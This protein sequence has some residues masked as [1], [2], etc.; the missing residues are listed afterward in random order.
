MVGQPPH[1]RAVL[2]GRHE[3]TVTPVFLAAADSWGFRE[4]FREGMEL[5]KLQWLA[6]EGAELLRAVARSENSFIILGAGREPAMV[7]LSRESIDDLFEKPLAGG[8][9]GRTPL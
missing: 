8:Q 1:E 2:V 7:R 3:N 6:V 5:L 9:E 4:M